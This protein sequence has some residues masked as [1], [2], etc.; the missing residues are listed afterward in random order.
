MSIKSRLIPPTGYLL[1]FESAARLGSLTKAADE[2][3]VTTTAVSKQVKNLENFLNIQLFTR[4]KQGVQLTAQGYQYLQ[5]VKEALDILSEETKILDNSSTAV[6]LN[7]EVGPCF[8]HFWLLP[9]IEQFR[10]AHPEI[11]LNI[12]I[13]NERHIDASE[14]Y[15]VTFYY[16]TI[17]TANE[18]CQQIFAER[19]QLVCSPKFLESHGGYIDL[20]SI[21]DQPL[22]MLKKEMSFW[23]GWQSWANKAGLTY[24]IP[25]NAL[26]VDDQVAVIQAAINDTGIALVWDWHVSELIAKGE[27]VSVTDYMEFQEKAYFLHIADQENNLAAKTFVGWVQQQESGYR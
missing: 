21:F 22:I 11:M 17:A 2:L 15:D 19:I 6:T 18:N 13:S 10:Q 1:V 12:T 20:Q 26:M 3:C 16:A 8:M 23:E 24:R 14:H 25:N 7:L 4:S 5:R 9:K 27:L